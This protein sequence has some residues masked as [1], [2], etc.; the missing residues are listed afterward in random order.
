MPE[1]RMFIG[2]KIIRAYSLS[3]RSFESMKGNEWDGSEDQQ[4]YCVEYPDGY[5]SWSPRRTF[6]EAYR[7][8]SEDEKYLLGINQGIEPATVTGHK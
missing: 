7:M 2:C 5:V 1:K 6:E 3:K 8:I 4:G